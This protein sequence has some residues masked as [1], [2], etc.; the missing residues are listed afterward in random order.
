MIPNMATVRPRNHEATGQA[1]PGALAV[2][3]LRIVQFL[4]MYDSYFY[5]RTHRKRVIGGWEIAHPLFPLI[6]TLDM[7]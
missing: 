6:L 2:A 4:N 1:V 5:A 3:K 7:G